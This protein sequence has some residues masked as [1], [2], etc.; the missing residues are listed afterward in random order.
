MEEMKDSDIRWIGQIPKNWKVIRVKDAFTRKKAKAKQEN[1][2]ILSLARSGVKVRDITNNE[3]Q[4][5]ENY[6]DYNPVMVDDLLLNPMDLISG[7]NCNISRVEGVIS[8]AY[9]NLRYKNGINPEFYNFYF[10]YQYWCKAFFAYGKGVSFEN[11]WTLNYDTLER[12]PLI[13]PPIE[14]Q[15]RIVK[16]LKGKCAEIDAL[17]MDIEKQIETLE[18]YKKSIITEAVTKGLDP[19]VEMKD[20]GISYIGNIPKHW[21]VTNLKYL[22]KCQNGISKGGEYF[23][24]GFP[25]V[26]YGDVYKNYSIPQN[27]DGLIMSTKTEQNIYSVKYGD[28]FFTRTSETIEEIGFA[29]T[30]LKSI[31]NSVFAGFLIRFRPTSS[32][33]I[34]EFSKFYFRSNIH[35]KFFVKEMNLVTRA[36]LSQNLLGRLPVLL[37]PLC[38]Q[39][40]IAINLEKKCAEID[41][42]IEEKIEQLETLEQY[43]K[44]LIYEYVTGKKEVK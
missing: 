44:S 30:C 23:G 20:S 39:Q 16:F 10:K 6:S 11:R 36:S 1:P 31:D 33:L 21:K 29:S 28:V 43:K 27:V 26:S 34:P 32:D 24:N 4:L 22:G 18:E 3:G 8:P 2:V 5:A 7:D 40:M 42:A 37:P 12:F 25:F 15:N 13:L 35:R 9:V 38:E 17:H 14:E 19:D 41:G